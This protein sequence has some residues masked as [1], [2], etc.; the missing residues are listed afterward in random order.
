MDERIKIWQQFEKA[1][2]SKFNL[3]SK[4]TDSEDFLHYFHMTHIGGTAD[5]ALLGCSKFKSI[6]QLY[7]EMVTGDKKFHG[8]MATKIGIALE[9]LVIDEASKKLKAE[10]VERD[11]HYQDLS[12]P[13]S[14]CQI[15]SLIK[16]KGETI[17]LE[18]KTAGWPKGEWGEGCTVADDGTICGV[19]GEIPPYYIVQCQKQ[20]YVWG[21]NFMFLACIF[22]ATCTLVIYKIDRDDNLIKQIIDTEDDFMFNHVIPQVPVESLIT[23]ADEDIVDDSSITA[24]ADIIKRLSE[25]EQLNSAYK[26]LSNEVAD[27][28]AILMSIMGSSSAIKDA[29]GKVL[30]KIS[31]IKVKPKFNEKSFKKENPT[32]WKKY[33]TA[34][35][36]ESKRFILK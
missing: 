13:W 8:N 11:G 30:A 17:P 10:V 25:L 7:S 18:A 29:S 9:A 4:S 22:R 12:R 3:N 1:Q 31:L 28:K 20:M 19:D 33:L 36:T 34:T 23:D 35:T 21:C 16:Y 14:V 5:A 26:Q 24:D 15:D 32:L 2:V 6:E 27:R